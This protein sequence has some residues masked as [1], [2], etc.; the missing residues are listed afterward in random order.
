MIRIELERRVHPAGDTE[1]AER[2]V[3]ARIALDRLSAARLQQEAALVGF[4][5]LAVRTIAPTDLHTGSVVVVL[6]A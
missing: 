4:R 3:H 1:T 5:P 6:R 2:P